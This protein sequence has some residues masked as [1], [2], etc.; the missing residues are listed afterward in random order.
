MTDFL[1]TIRRDSGIAGNAGAAKPLVLN[2]PG[3]IHPTFDFF[4][5]FRFLLGGE[6]VK[7]HSGHLHMKIQTI[8]QWTGDPRKIV[9]N[10]FG[11]TGAGLGGVAKIPQGQGFIAA[12]SIME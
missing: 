6:I 7:V 2:F 10:G 1:Q 5:T 12:T 11:G 4:R 9:G 3:G 8:Q